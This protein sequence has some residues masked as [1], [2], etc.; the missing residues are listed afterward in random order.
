MATAIFATGNVYYTN[1]T[2]EEVKT[3]IELGS[4]ISIWWF[5]AYGQ[6]Y[7]EKLWIPCIDKVDLIRTESDD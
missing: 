5:T 6:R 4:E 7:S 1:D 3:S 2:I